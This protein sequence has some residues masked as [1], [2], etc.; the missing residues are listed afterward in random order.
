MWH[1]IFQ[2]SSS[3]TLEFCKAESSLDDRTLMCECDSVL[4]DNWLDVSYVVILHSFSSNLEWLVTKI[5]EGIFSQLYF[6]AHFIRISQQ[7]MKTH[8][9]SQKCLFKDKSSSLGNLRIVFLVGEV[10]SLP[11]ST[12]MYPTQDSHIEI[13]NIY[14]K[15]MHLQP[16][17]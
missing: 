1:K 8:V 3:R 16:P 9:I 14:D 2:R 15:H 7:K 5:P 6:Y 4:H 11:T 13:C 17:F 12:F 10:V